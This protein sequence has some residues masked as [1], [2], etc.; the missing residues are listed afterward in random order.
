MWRCL[1]W[2]SASLSGA[3]RVC[4]PF[5]FRSTCGQVSHIHPGRQ[6]S[7]QESTLSP[8]ISGTGLAFGPPLPST[9]EHSVYF[10]VCQQLTARPQADATACLEGLQDRQ[11]VMHVSMRNAQMDDKGLAALLQ[12]L[13]TP[14]CHGVRIDLA[15][16]RLTDQGVEH[17]F[18]QMDA[19]QLSKRLLS[20]DVA[21]NRLTSKGLEPLCKCISANQMVR[22]R[23]LCLGGVELMDLFATKL[24]NSLAEHVSSCLEDLDMSYTGLGIGTS[25]PAAVAVLLQECLALAVIDLSGNHLQQNALRKIAQAL[26]GGSARE[27]HLAY[28]ASAW[29]GSEPTV[30]EYVRARSGQEGVQSVVVFQMCGFVINAAFLVA[31]PVQLQTCCAMRCHVLCQTCMHAASRHSEHSPILSSFFL[32]SFCCMLSFSN[33]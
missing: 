23:R 15:G 10:N 9:S 28:N 8:R 11:D 14:D 20:L 5:L 4:V 18:K 30:T 22:L 17:L 33:T 6:R 32:F 27:I 26:A 1:G 13:G 3:V 25:A 16:N 29:V 7:L 21:G 31:G 2:A 24:L 19:L 12:S